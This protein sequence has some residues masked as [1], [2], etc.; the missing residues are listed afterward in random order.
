MLTYSYKVTGVDAVVQSLRQLTIPAL[1]P[2]VAALLDE[3]GRDAADYPP[4]PPDSE[5]V[6]TNALRD[7]WL[8]SEPS[9]TISGSTLLGVLTNSVPYGPFVMG[10]EDQASVHAGRWRT[11]D[12][13]MDAW[14]Q[15][16]AERIEDALGR[17][18][19]A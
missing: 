4:P 9:V 16:A 14:E 17:L 10:A 18:V 13:I 7:G 2:T 8:D 5:Y 6:R 15:R 3:I 19:G 12:S 11:T 1:E